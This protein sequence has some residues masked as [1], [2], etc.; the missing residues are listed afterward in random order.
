[1]QRNFPIIDSLKDRLRDLFGNSSKDYLWHH[2]TVEEVFAKLE[3]SESGISYGLAR[4]KLRQSKREQLKFSSFYLHLYFLIGGYGLLAVLLWF[5]STS[6]FTIL[7]FAILV[8]ALLQIIRKIILSRR[9][10]SLQ[11]SQ[12]RSSES[13]NLIY[14]LRDGEWYRVPMSGLILGDVVSLQSG[15]RLEVAVRLCSVE[16]DFQVNQT[17]IGGTVGTFKQVESLPLEVDKLGRTNMLYGGVVNCGE[18]KGIVVETAKTSSILQIQIQHLERDAQILVFLALLFSLILG[19]G[20]I[21]SIAIAL[22]I[23]PFDWTEQATLAQLYGVTSLEK[24]GIQLKVSIEQLAQLSI[25]S[26]IIDER[27]DL[28][29]NYAQPDSPGLSLNGILRG[30]TEAAE[31]LS[32]RVQMP[33]YSY[34]DASLERIRLWQRQNQKVAIIG[35]QMEDISLFHQADLGICDRTNPVEVIESAKLILP[36]QDFDL[37]AIALLAARGTWQRMHQVIWFYA[38]SIPSFLVYALVTDVNLIQTLWI[39]A[40]V[41]PLL[42]WTLWQESG[43]LSLMTLPVSYFH[44]LLT[45]ERLS[46][47]GLG[48]NAIVL[49]SLILFN[50]GNGSGSEKT[51]LGIITLVVGLV[52]YAIAMTRSPFVKNYLLMGAILLISITLYFVTRISGGIS[53]S[54]WLIAILAGTCALWVQQFTKS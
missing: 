27:T 34:G 4:R 52:L 47:L 30:N 45:F 39:G 23:Y 40:L 54:Q 42:S 28:S 12:S 20:L 11:A 50:F 13:S 19:K 41:L 16:E 18:A 24:F 53:G 37:I 33:I 7:G 49:P 36:M 43:S 8:A 6:E 44:K 32:Q 3:T 14:V 48:V 46:G 2:L 38:V 10:S 29:F 21:W 1:M 15:D 5:N 31:A 17:S 22:L 26:K 51:G 35:Q 25:I 9:I